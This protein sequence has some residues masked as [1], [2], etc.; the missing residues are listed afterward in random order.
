VKLRV[1]GS[2]PG[3]DQPVICPVLVGRAPALAALERVVERAC[4]GQGATVLVAGEAGVGKSRLVAEMVARV[5][6]RGFAVLEGHCFEPDSAAPYAP[7]VDLL[8]GI[9][10]EG[11]T[12]EAARIVGL[13]TNDLV[14][15]APDLASFLPGPTGEPEAVP[16]VPDP[17][18]DRRRLF[19]ALARLLVGLAASR[20]LFAIV[21]DVHWSDGTSL[22]FLLYLA[23]R[24]RDHPVVLVLTYRDDEPSSDLTRFLAGL[25][26]ERLAVE[27]SL[28]RLSPAEVGA[29]CHAILGPQGIVPATLVGELYALSEGN[30]FFVEE[31]LKVLL[32]ASDLVCADGAWVSTSPGGWRIPRS[33]QDAV[34]RRAERLSP[35]ARRVL[36]LAAVVG[37]RFDFALLQ[38]LAGLEED[39]LV[40]QLK[41]LVAAQLVVELSADRFAFRHALTRQAVYAQMLARER[42]SLHRAVVDTLERLFAAE[43]EAHLAELA[44]HAHAAEDGERAL[45]YARRAAERALAL[46]AT[47]EAVEQLTRALDAAEHLGGAAPAELYRSRGLAFET[48]G[49]LDRAARDLA[50]ALEGARAADDLQG[51]WHAALDLG[52]IWGARDYVRAGDYL[53]L[54]LAL[55][56]RLDDP[57]NLAHTLNGLGNWLANTGHPTE[58]VA[59]HREA[60]VLLEAAGDESGVAATLDLLGM[61]TAFCGDRIGAVGYFDRAVARF[62]ALGDPR[63]LASAL[64]ARGPFA[65][66]PVLAETTYA[67]GWSLADCLR[68]AEEASELA[69]TIDWPAGLAF[70]RVG[71]GP[72]CAEMGEYGLALMWSRETLRIATEIAHDQWLAAAHYGLGSL[73]IHLLQPDRAI[74]HLETGLGLARQVGSTWWAGLCLVG[75]AMAYL[76]GNDLRRAEQ[77]LAAAPSSDAVVHAQP[78]TLSER[79]LAWARAELA[80][81][82]GDPAGALRIADG[83]RATVPGEPVEQPIPALAKLRGEALTAMGRLDDAAEA[84]AEAERGA[85]QLGLR[86]LLWQVYRARG[87]LLLRRKRPREAT[88]AFAVARELVGALAAT[89]GVVADREHF[90]AAALRT[91]PAE[92]PL[93]PLRAARMAYGGLTRREREVAALVAQGKS[94]REIAAALYLG[95]GTVA[96]HVSNILGKLGCTSRAQIAAWVS[97]RR[98]A[99]SG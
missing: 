85:A 30:P 98:P 62:R 36:G 81:H 55:A 29:M 14:R 68:D 31:I 17:E 21:E 51:E 66:S 61:A 53:Q 77:T 60:L 11:Y 83:L 69:R 75:L 41:E 42:R 99:D 73:Y 97:E 25:D 35:T 56:R 58:G 34:C 67:A 94:N 23:R 2:N 45:T 82:R 27:L 1:Q 46:H 71:G 16:P 13:F 52:T 15:L 22:E 12:V 74:E 38:A 37:Q 8:R 72:T 9:P 90:R 93:S 20:P 76:L 70:A 44:Y 50:L 19:E 18:R 92:R 59:A 10:R 78:A 32:T 43:P 80:L 88:G 87:R 96:T 7:L 40:A 28:A 64:A 95:E 54:A 84:L 3:P 47:R 48:L 26:R 63:G 6:T 49:E 79:R 4:A 65:A 91:L 89:V 5:R 33:V 86:P 39:A 57:A 24:V